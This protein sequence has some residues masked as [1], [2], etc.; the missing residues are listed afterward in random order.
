MDSNGK[1]G[2]EMEENEASKEPHKFLFVSFESLSGDLASW[3]RQ[4][5]IVSE[6][7]AIAGV[8][9]FANTASVRELLLG[10]LVPQSGEGEIPVNLFHV[11]VTQNEVRQSPAGHFNAGRTIREIR[12]SGYSTR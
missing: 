3:I 11:N 7:M 2:K 5:A 8:L 9:V 10:L 6:L 1:N 12:L 4:K